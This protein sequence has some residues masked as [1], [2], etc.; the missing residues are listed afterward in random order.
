[1]EG[2]KGA[3]AV[4]AGFVAVLGIFLTVV[5]E[6]S[7]RQSLDLDKVERRHNQRMGRIEERATTVR[8]IVLKNRD[9]ITRLKII[10]GMPM[11]PGGPDAGEKP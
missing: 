7:D 8:D 4:V 5:I 2:A 3:I 1:M 10:A 9:D 11:F 6:V